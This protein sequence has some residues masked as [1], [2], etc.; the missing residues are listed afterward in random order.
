MSWLM[1]GGANSHLENNKWTVQ[2]SI[3]IKFTHF[4]INKTSIQFLMRFSF[5]KSGTEFGYSIFVAWYNYPDNSR[6]LRIFGTM[7]RKPRWFGSRGCKEFV[8]WTL[9]GVW[10]PNDRNWM[11]C[12]FGSWSHRLISTILW[13][14]SFCHEYIQK[15]VTNFKLIYID[16]NPL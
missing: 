14:W 16:L 4:E 7:L 12:S 2:K 3:T 1:S 6:M 5:T 15:C 10:Q 9:K 11:Y 13:F 8:Q